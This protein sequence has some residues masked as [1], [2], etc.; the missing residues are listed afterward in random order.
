[1]STQQL[2]HSRIKPPNICV[3]YKEVPQGGNIDTR[4]TEVSEGFT[5]SHDML[6]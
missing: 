2:L 6:A 1:M 3:Y 4:I 5:M